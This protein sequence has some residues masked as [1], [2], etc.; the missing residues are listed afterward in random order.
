MSVNTNTRRNYMRKHNIYRNEIISTYSDLNYKKEQKYKTTLHLYQIQKNLYIYL[1]LD[2]SQK[3]H[4]Q[5]RAKNWSR[6]RQG[7]SSTLVR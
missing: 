3:R 4:Q 7:V 5:R 1:V 6:N 2:D